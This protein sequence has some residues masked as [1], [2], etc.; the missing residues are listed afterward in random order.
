MA[1]NYLIPAHPLCRIMTCQCLRQLKGSV[2]KFCI[3]STHLL[4]ENG[5]LHR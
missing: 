5:I 3:Y 1:I 4:K 2:F